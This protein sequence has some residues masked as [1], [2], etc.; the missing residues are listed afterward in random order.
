[1]GQLHDPSD[2]QLLDQQS[3]NDESPIQAPTE[4]TDEIP[5]EYAMSVLD[6]FPE[7]D[8][9][10]IEELFV[11]D[12]PFIKATAQTKYNLRKKVQFLT[13]FLPKRTRFLLGK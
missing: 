13:L 6:W 7:L 1:V 4:T 2:N 9:E 8:D 3:L 10:H 11:E 5:L 12:T